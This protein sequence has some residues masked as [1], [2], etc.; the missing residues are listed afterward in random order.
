MYIVFTIILIFIFILLSKNVNCS[1]VEENFKIHRN[2]RINRRRFKG[3]NWR[4]PRRGRVFWPWRYPIRYNYYPNYN[5]TY[6]GIQNPVEKYII[7]V[8]PKTDIHPF[9]NEGSELGYMIT[10]GQSVNCGTSGASLSLQYGKTYEFDVFTSK[11]CITGKDIFQP[12]FFTTDKHGGNMT[13]K[14]FNINPTV[15]GT[16]KITI[17]RDL[18]SQFFYQ[19]AVSKDV[20]GYVFLHD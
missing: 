20:G 15:N 3:Q 16:L 17:T 5:Y 18:P 4:R 12:F 19:S 7:R 6:T 14:L 11:D 9:K 13:G 8:G 2:R 10:K 1:L